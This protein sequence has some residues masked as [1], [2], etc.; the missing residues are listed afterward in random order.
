MRRTALK[1]PALYDEM[2][3][4]TIDPIPY[5]D[6]A[7]IMA[8]QEFFIKEGMTQELRQPIDLA[9][10]IDRTFVDHAIGVLGRYP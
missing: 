10:F 9:P 6:Q 1:D 4:S 3:F 5:I 8:Q 7:A 2:S